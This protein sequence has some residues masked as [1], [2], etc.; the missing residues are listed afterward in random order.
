LFGSKKIEVKKWENAH[1]D[2]RKYRKILQEVK[3]N[4]IY[5]ED[6]ALVEIT[7]LLEDKLSQNMLY[8]LTNH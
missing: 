1:T 3:D 5:L 7:E 2:R 6:Y 4:S 8:E